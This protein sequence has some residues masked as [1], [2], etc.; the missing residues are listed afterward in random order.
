[1]SLNNQPNQTRP[2]IININL[3]K[4]LFNPFPVSVDKCGGIC[5]AVIDPYA[6]I[7]VPKLKIMT[8]KV[9]DFLP[10]INKTRFLVQHES[11]KCKCWSNESVCNS[12]QK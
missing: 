5:N 3:S 4:T 9:F 1:M 10:R 8:V 2:I 12:Q 7:C 6:R 11:C